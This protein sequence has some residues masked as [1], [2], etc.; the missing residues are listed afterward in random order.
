[1]KNNESWYWNNV[2]AAVALTLIVAMIALCS[3]LAPDRP[4]KATVY[5]NDSLTIQCIEKKAGA[6]E[7]VTIKDKG[8]KNDRK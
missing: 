7:G 5:Q 4:G 8:V 6:C 3:L 2:N 1:M